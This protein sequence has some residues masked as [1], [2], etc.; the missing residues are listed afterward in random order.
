LKLEIEPMPD[1][2]ANVEGLMTRIRRTIEDRLNF[3]PDVIAVPTGSL[4]RFEL[5]GQRFFRSSE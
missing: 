5:K 2:A 1:A 4:P 3:H